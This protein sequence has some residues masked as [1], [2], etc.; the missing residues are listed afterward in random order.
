[1]PGAPD[2]VTSHLP[3]PLTP[4]VGREDTVRAVCDLLRRPEVRLLTLTGPGGIGKT[5]LGLAVGRELANEFADGIFFVS[6]A[7]IRD[8]DLVLPAIAQALGLREAGDWPLIERLYAALSEKRMLLLLDNFEQVLPAAPRLS[9]LITLCPEIKLLVTSRAVLHVSGEYEFPIAPLA[10]PDPQH[11]S[12]GEALA[13]NP[14][15]ALFI[16]RAQ[17]SKPDFHL[18]TANARAVAETCLRLDGLPLA[19]ELAAARIKLLPPQALLARLERRLQVL[20]SMAQDIPARQHT[21]RETL[22]WSYDLLTA[23]EQELFRRLAVFVGGCT[24]EAAEAVVGALGDGEQ[25]ILDGAASLIDQSLLRQSEQEAREPRFVMLETIREYGWE[26]LHASGEATALQRAHAAYYLALAEEAESQ[27]QG[28]EQQQWLARLEQEHENLRAALRWLEEQG[29]CEQALRLCGAL[30]WFWWI[31]GRVKEARTFLERLLA[32]SAAIAPQIRARALN[33]AGALASLQGQV[34][35]AERLCQES[36]ALF[37]ELNDPQ[38]TV[39]AL[40]TLGYG[41]MEQSHYPQAHAWVEE[42]VALARAA[43]YSWGLAYALEVLADVAFSQGE[44]TSA[45]ALAEESLATSRV[46][47]DTAGCALRQRLLGLIQLFQGESETAHAL[48]EESLVQSRAVGDRR[49]SAYSLIMGAYAEIVQGGFTSAGGRLEEGLALLQEVG[50][51]RGLAWG[52]YG[53]GWVSLSKGEAARASAQ[54][55]ETLGL[56]QEIGQQWFIALALEGLAA[57]AAQE[58][59][60]WAARL[61]GAAERLR[62]T[63]GGSI[64]PMVQN[65][66]EPFL[67]TARAQLGERA[68]A[69]LWSEGR[70]MTLETVLGA[71]GKAAL[72]QNPQPLIAPKARPSYPAGLTAREVE[73][74]RWV[75]AGYTD[76]EI[77]E[78]LIIS[79]RTVSTHLTSIYNK[80]GAASRIAATRFAV[81]QRLV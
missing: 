36:L 39:I 60:A 49:G 71:Q 30:W 40:W 53:L 68:F 23:N 62:E 76:N 67:G 4:L 41:A 73:V 42:A 43:K 77:A 58:Q 63:I 51:R 33:A 31:R 2:L 15:V 16:Q 8:P 1:M 3:L 24:L 29:E 57:A 21:L 46:I 11:L 78:K 74:L 10:L 66:Y 38:G 37:R 45:R 80:L 18:T 5:R 19:I 50:D 12:E 7:T 6:L 48:L 28:A 47:G 25:S 75:A 79:P 64:P 26:C 70:Q 35:Q 59:P 52:L 56:L 81:E 20:T 9:D 65:V 27:L 32:G 55:Q 17:A 61:W 72:A 54:W 13:A 34:A 14:A 69:N 22:T 44:Y